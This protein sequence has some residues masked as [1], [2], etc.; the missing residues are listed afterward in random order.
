MNNKELEVAASGHAASG[1]GTACRGF[2]R[3]HGIMYIDVGVIFRFGTYSALTGA[4]GGLENLPLSLE[5]GVWKYRW[6][7]DKPWIE[8]QGRMLRSELADKGIAALTSEYSSD[9]RFFRAFCGI[10]ESVL[11]SYEGKIAD[12][13]SLGTILL[14][15][16]PVK[17]FLTADIH[18]RAKRRQKEFADLGQNLTIEQVIAHLNERDSLDATRKLDPLRIAEGAIEIDTSRMEVE[19]VIDAMSLTIP[20]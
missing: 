1:K 4:A 5:K 10:A 6:E 8:L 3:K 7:G 17:F 2:A 14:P 16:A 11:G 12:G 18:T 9:P 20:A 19:E 15:D 13:R